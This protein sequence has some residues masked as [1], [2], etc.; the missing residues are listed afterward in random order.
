MKITVFTIKAIQELAEKGFNTSALLEMER[1]AYTQ[2]AATLPGASPEVIAREAANCLPQGAKLHNYYVQTLSGL[3]TAPLFRLEE[4][5][6]EIGDKV[7]LLESAYVKE[8]VKDSAAPLA[9]KSRLQGAVAEQYATLLE[10]ARD[11]EQRSVISVVRSSRLQAVTEP[12]DGPLGA[13]YNK[14]L[15]ILNQRN[16]LGETTRLRMQAA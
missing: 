14:A 7:R 16:S 8:L 3:N 9:A 12:S 10:A 6:D 11:L 13:I 4:F 2:A 1:V 5:A 15:A